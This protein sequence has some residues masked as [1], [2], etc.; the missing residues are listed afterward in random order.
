MFVRKI[1]A[2]FRILV[3][4]I[5][6]TIFFVRREN[7]ATEA[8]PAVYGYGHTFPEAYTSWDSEVRGSESCQRLVRYTFDGMECVVRFESDGYLPS[9]LP[10]KSKSGGNRQMNV[11]DEG[12]EGLLKAL[13]GS[14][15][16]TAASAKDKPLTVLPGGDDVPQQA[17]FDLKT[18]TIR[19]K[20]QEEEIIAEQLSRLWVSQTPN[21]VLAYHRQGKFEDIEIKDLRNEVDEWESEN[22]EVLRRFAVLL[23]KICNLARNSED[24][25]I[26]IRRCEGQV[27]V[28]EI[29]EPGGE[30]GDALSR[31]VRERWV[32]V[33]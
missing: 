31:E 2:R 4:V 22:E 17:V 24:G 6:D 13:G 8:I 30:V 9:L 7:E 23:R 19:K 14:S 1:D 25:R 16:S 27:G 3:E 10:P 28:L 26:E 21:F 29:R 12:E 20:E 5:G 18:R 32:R 15:I 11:K 33:E